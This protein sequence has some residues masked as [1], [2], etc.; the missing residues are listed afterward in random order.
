MEEESLYMAVSGGREKEISLFLQPHMEEC[1]LGTCVAVQSWLDIHACEVWKELESTIHRVLH[2]ARKRQEQKGKGDIQYLVFSFMRYG[3]CG[4]KPEIFIE[5]LDDA[6]YL[7]GQEAACCYCPA[8]L[9]DRFQKD[10]DILYRK[11]EGGF[12]RLQ[13]YE[14]EGIR[15]EYAGYYCSI[16]LRMIQEL[17]GRIAETVRKNG[18]H[19][20]ERF[21]IIY[22]EYMGR[23]VVLYGKGEEDEIFYAGNK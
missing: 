7:D 3:T 20:T 2:K 10:C 14:L 19:T 5:A 12:V 22:G 17:A 6:F 21:M 9:Q 13:D 16:L 23:A 11:T 8:F 1:Y 18:I 15:K 4:N